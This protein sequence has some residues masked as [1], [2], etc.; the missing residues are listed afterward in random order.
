MR[1]PHSGITATNYYDIPLAVKLAG[2]RR[3]QSR[4]SPPPL[5]E[6]PQGKPAAA[7]K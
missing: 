2:L 3:L 6:P 1:C 7:A 5:P 4:F